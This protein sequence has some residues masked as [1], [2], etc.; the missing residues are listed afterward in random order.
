MNM[1]SARKKSTMT[2]LPQK[3]ASTAVV[4][5]WLIALC[6]LCNV[7]LG[8]GA[9]YVPDEFVRPMINLHKSIGITVLGLV[10]ARIAWR[11]SH[12]PPA[13]PDD[14]PP[15]ERLTAHSVHSFLYLLILTIPI[16]G[17][18]HDSAFSQAAKHPLILFGV[19]PWFRLG[20]IAHLNPM[21]KEQI[22]GL[23]GTIHTGL[24]YV[25]YGVVG[26]H[27]IGAL[28]HQIIDKEPEI[29]RMWF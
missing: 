20:F 9:N 15:L 24:G 27:I 3:Y 11:L 25:L 7:I 8:L 14:Y 6:I 5:H 1:P 18:I 22:H 17:W 10:L 13:L 4:L 26:L 19:I 23:F 16:T 29:E 28:K 21:T 12:K 2:V